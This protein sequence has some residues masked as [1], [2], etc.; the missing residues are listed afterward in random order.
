MVDLQMKNKKNSWLILGIVGLVFVVIGAYLWTTSLMDSAQTYRSPLSNT[1]PLPGQRLG[2]PITH[3]VVIVLV[4]AL[5]FDTSTNT[6]IMP[7]LSLLRSQGASATMHSQPPS[8]SAPA[9]TTILTGAWPEI[10]DSQP[11]NPP[12]ENSARAFTQD[13]IF[14]AVHRAGLHTAV[15]GYIWFE[16]MLSNSGVN[17]GFYT[18]G[19]DNAADI[20]VI[21]AAVSW[22]GDDHQLI[23]IHLD[24]VDFAGHEQ[25]GPQDP[26]WNAAANRVDTMINNIVSILDFSQDTLLVISDH[27]QI[28]RGGHGGPEPI[29][30]LE[31]FILTGAGI[32]PGNYGDI[33]MVDIAPTLAVLLGTNIP[34]SSQGSPLLNM[35]SLS[36]DR[37]S[38]INNAIEL[39]QARLFSSYTAAIGSA[40]SIGN[41]ETVLATQ[42][43]INQAHL[44]RVAKER[45]WRNVLAVFLAIL[46]AYVIYLRKDK[47]VIWLF[48]G[49]FLYV[50]LF[51]IRYAVIDGRTYSLASVEGATWLI[52]YTASTAAIAGVL[53]WLVPMT[54][55]KVL[56]GNPRKSAETVVAY[57]WSTIYFLSLPILLSFAINGLTV[58]W[59]LPEFYSMYIGLLSLIQ[60]M[61]LS[62]VGLVLTGIM[63]LISWFI[64]KLR[65]GPLSMD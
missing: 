18:S 41:G 15:S 56:P 54:A 60:V 39:Q 36:P 1:P 64:G 57:I 35:L 11:F 17:E 16:K 44:A 24:Q 9:W 49:S 65:P 50:L 45:I 12:D 6:T 3:R 37:V 34:A 2:T 46:P 51:N 22:L 19:E 8:F 48:A 7:T 62:V 43:A 14:A 27:G 21:N 13:D 32:I 23:L 5:R 58:T 38:S 53:G 52:A 61:I 31:P 28:D 33:N 4:D 10:N 47:K 29:T 25:G 30:L 63:V 20:E 59:T 42:S 26:N 40:S 55:L